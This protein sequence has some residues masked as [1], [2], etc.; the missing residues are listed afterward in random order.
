MIIFRIVLIQLCLASTIFAV[1][2][3]D[4]KENQELTLRALWAA[5]RKKCFTMELN[6]VYAFRVKNEDKLNTH[7][8]LIVGHIW[9]PDVDDDNQR[10]DF[11]AYY[12]DMR[13]T[14]K[15]YTDRFWGAKCFPEANTWECKEGNVFKFAGEVGM[16]VDVEYFHDVEEI[17]GEEGIIH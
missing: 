5:C 6:K 12:F 16:G 17:I 11:E 4:L 10:W 8:R 7:T 15:R 2:R 9:K 14:G 3:Y 13:A 1:L